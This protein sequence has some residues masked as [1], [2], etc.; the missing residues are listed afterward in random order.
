MECCLLWHGFAQ[1]QVTILT[2]ENTYWTK[3]GIRKFLK[4]PQKYKRPQ[5]NVMLTYLE[6]CFY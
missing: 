4:K 2:Y 5:K 3:V 6:N 1:L